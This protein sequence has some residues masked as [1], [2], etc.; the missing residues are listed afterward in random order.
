MYGGNCVPTGRHTNLSQVLQINWMIFTWQA[1]ISVSFTLFSENNSYTIE[2]QKVGIKHHNLPY[3]TLIILRVTNDEN[4]HN[5]MN[6]VM[7]G[8]D[9]AAPHFSL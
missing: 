4:G 5:Y 3:M 9:D 6:N 2:S 7:F 8:F 1:S